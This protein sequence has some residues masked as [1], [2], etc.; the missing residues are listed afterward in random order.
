[1]FKFFKKSLTKV[2]SV[3]FA[4]MF[5]SSG[6]FADGFA[7]VLLLGNYRGGKTQ[8]W[9]RLVGKPYD[10]GLRDSDKAVYKIL[11]LKNDTT[12]ERIA[13]VKF[14]DSPGA[15][16]YY[17]KVVE[18]ARGAHIVFVV[19]DTEQDIDSTKGARNRDY[20]DKL[21]AD[22]R[23]KIAPKAKIAFV[24]SKT[25]SQG[26]GSIIRY[27]ENIDMLKKVS[28][29]TNS[30]L[31]ITSARTGQGID[32]IMAYIKT[33]LAEMNLPEEDVDDEENV[34]QLVDDPRL[35]TKIS[36]LEEEIKTK[37]EEI[38][39]KEKEISEKNEGGC[40]IM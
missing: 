19:H 5:F 39:R 24:A 33:N 12:G 37:D 34:L 35:T 29:T 21:Y 26:F 8:I 30:D 22:L 9:R 15:D 4:V 6:V 40:V 20:F 11:N 10:D 1:M 16:R 27:S 25:D 17:E 14:W 2:F 13:T 32:E 23:K 38:K 3:V 31:F 7:K 36:K 28:S 18:M